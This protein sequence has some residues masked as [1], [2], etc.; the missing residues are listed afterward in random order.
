MNMIVWENNFRYFW[1]IYAFRS[2]MVPRRTNKSFFP[3]VFYPL[4]I[5]YFDSRPKF[6]IFVNII[7][8][9]FQK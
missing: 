1:S 6:S 7:I 8:L 4:D 9:K 5:F 3:N 2:Q